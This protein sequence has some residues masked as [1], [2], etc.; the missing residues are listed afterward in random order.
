MNQG[1]IS[2]PW[3]EARLTPFICVDCTRF[4]LPA[5]GDSIPFARAAIGKAIMEATLATLL[6]GWR[7]AVAESLLSK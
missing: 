7:A 4:L 6:S 3:P 2:T 1:P 5:Q